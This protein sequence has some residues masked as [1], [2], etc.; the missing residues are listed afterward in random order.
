MTTTQGAASYL[1][2]K[3]LA[4]RFSTRSAP[5][6]NTRRAW[7]EDRPRGEQGLARWATTSYLPSHGRP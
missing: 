6:G 3:Y 7:N 1:P 2:C 4:E 5:R